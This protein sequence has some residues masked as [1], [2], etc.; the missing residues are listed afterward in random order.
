M[1]IATLKVQNI[2]EKDFKTLNTW[3]DILCSWIRTVTKLQSRV[4]IQS[5]AYIRK[6]DFIETKPY[7]YIYVF[8]MVVFML[9]WHS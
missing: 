7:P 6:Q 4:Q 2:A 8:T 1:E 3:R 5:A 9:Q